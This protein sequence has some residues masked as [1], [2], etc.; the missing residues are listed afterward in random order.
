LV[1]APIGA[2]L[3][4]YLTLILRYIEMR[5]YYREQCLF[6]EFIRRENEMWDKFLTGSGAKPE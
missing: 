4:T 1:Q 2:R 6:G 3:V 5:A